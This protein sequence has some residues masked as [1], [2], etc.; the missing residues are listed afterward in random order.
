MGKWV[1]GKVVGRRN[2]T[3]SLFSL[4]IDAAEV[5]F[6]AGQFARLA[7][8]APQGSR[9]P[10]LGRPYSFVN[11]PADAPHEFYVI[12]VPEGPLSPRLATLVPDDPVWLLPR[13]NG[14]FTVA[15]LPAAEVLWCLATGTGLG[16]YLSI[17]RTTEP[18]AKFD[19]CVLVHAVRHA[20]ELTY[21]DTIDGI[22]A[23]HPGAFTYVPIVSRAPHPGAL[24]GRI[25]AAIADRRLEMRAG[26]AMSPENSHVML[27]GNPAMVE[28]TQKVLETL[29]MRR[30]RRRE[31]GHYSAET[32]W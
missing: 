10:M 1:E 14:F 22:A 27:C 30:H 2:W 19:R 31:P 4:Q 20:E 3:S 32:Y 23:A 18:W 16:P 11:N 5:T 9:E 13:A 15:E 29:G 12:I 7:L 21:R 26:I 28:D 17:L 24:T 25:P 8:P 6:E